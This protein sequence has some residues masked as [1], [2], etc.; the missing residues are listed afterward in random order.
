MTDQKDWPVMADYPQT[1]QGW[2]EYANHWLGY[3]RSHAATPAQ[4]PQ[5][6]VEDYQAAMQMGRQKGWQ[7][8]G[9]E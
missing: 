8:S 4:V 6:A 1:E 3:R 2:N 7:E 5:R 9:P